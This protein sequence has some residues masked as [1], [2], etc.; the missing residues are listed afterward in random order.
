MKDYNKF[1]KQIDSLKNDIN[2]KI[3]DFLTNSQ[4]LRDFIDFRNKNF[5]HYSIRNNILI[6]RQD[7]TASMIA[8]FKK[9]QGTRI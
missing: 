8:S 7:K 9:W 1:I 5:Y 3:K 6:F 2:D 4:E